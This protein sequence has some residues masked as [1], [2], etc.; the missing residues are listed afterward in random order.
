MFSGFNL[1]IDKYGKIFN[2]EG[3]EELREKGETHLEDQQNEFRAT[4]EKCIMQEKIDGSELQDKWFPQ[5]N[6]DVFISHS[7]QDKE[8]ACALAGWLSS[9]FKLKCFIDSNVW[10]YV[11]ELRELLNSKVSDKREDVDGG[12]LY[13]HQSCNAVSQHVDT[14]LTIALYQMIDQVES[15]FLLN[16]EHAVQTVRE[17]CQMDRT[18]SPWIY[19]ELICTQLVRKKPLLAY[20]KYDTRYLEHALSESIQFLGQLSIS[21][22]V[23]L[24]HLIQVDEDDL[25]NWQWEY[26]QNGGEYNKYSL[27]ALYK[28]KRPKAVERTKELFSRLDSESIGILK[29]IYSGERVQGEEW[30]G[31]EDEEYESVCF[32]G[33]CI[34]GKK[35][36]KYNG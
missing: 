3:F 12:Y 28:Y 21:Y 25:I 11:E 2:D 20:R 27:D 6:A 5:I 22:K 35:W 16:T 17:E 15:V 36:E 24:A 26:K 34:C 30:Q 13:N 33:E 4:I 7:H 32:C 29:R 18:Y 31:M 1:H 10:G 19:S 9:R 23:S 14:M 8:L